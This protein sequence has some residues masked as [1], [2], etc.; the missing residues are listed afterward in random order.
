[1][2]HISKN[3]KLS[4]VIKDA[5][6]EIQSKRLVFKKDVIQKQIIVKKLL[7]KAVKKITKIAS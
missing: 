7:A 3:A 5:K 2:S 1:L 6:V 4:S